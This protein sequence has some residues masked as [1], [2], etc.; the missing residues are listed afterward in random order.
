[1]S[2]NNN[3]GKLKY[4]I[5]KSQD[6][7]ESRY[8][9]I[10]NILFYCKEIPSDLYTQLNLSYNNFR[11]TISILKQKGYLKRISQDG[12]V[13]YILTAKGRRLTSLPEYSKYM[14]CAWDEKRQYDIKRRNRKRQFAYLYALFDRVGIKYESFAKPPI[15]EV[16]VYGNEV[17]F[18]TALDFKRMLG[19]EANTFKGS[20]LLGFLIGR[21]Q[22]IPVY[23]TN[24]KMKTFGR[25]EILV[26]QFMSRYFS[27]E[28]D[29]AVLICND[30]EAV[31]DIAH[32]IID[33][34][35]ND[36]KKGINTALY[37]HFYIFPSNDTFY[38]HYKDLYADHSE[39][40]QWLIEQNEIDTSDMDSYGRYRLKIGTGFYL[41]HPVWICVGNVDIVKLK[42][43]V[44]NSVNNDSTSYLI[45]NKRDS[46]VME[47]I[48]R[49]DDIRVYSI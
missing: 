16:T 33:N 41:D 3:T 7:Y 48:T 4:S 40:L 45:C 36:Y 46:Y 30:D 49:N 6:K 42:H 12:A 11:K 22:I 15:T 13:G 29:T 1:M 8:A 17:F 14:D 43:F 20:R 24:Q 32:Q 35:R 37:S 9:R 31:I 2:E 38:S 25:H 26:P 21:G 5:D 18:Y 34:N 47:R 39:T 27:T 10:L 44:Y 19:V 28:V 23:R